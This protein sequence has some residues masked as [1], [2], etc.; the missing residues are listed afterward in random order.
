[1]SLIASSDDLGRSNAI[2]GNGTAV[3]GPNR[4]PGFKDRP[5]L[6][7]INAV[8]NSLY[9]IV[10]CLLAVYDIKRPADDQGTVIKLKPE[11][12]SGFLS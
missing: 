12:R 6:P 2:P 5:F 11:F 3:V 8:D 4:L 1:M 10:S 9:S 7:Y